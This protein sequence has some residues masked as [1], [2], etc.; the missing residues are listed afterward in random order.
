MNAQGTS[1]KVKM[2]LFLFSLQLLSFLSHAQDR[3]TASFIELTVSGTSTLHD[4]TMKSV[5]GDCTVQISVAPGGQITGLSALNFSTPVN[6]LKSDHSGMDNNAYK[7]LK[8]DKNPVISYNLSSV[9][10]APAAGGASTVTCKG[11]V[12][13][14]GATRDEEVVALCK[15]NPDNTITVKG[16]RKISM[17]DFKIDPPTFMLGTIKTGNDIVLNFTLVLKKS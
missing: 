8:S 7:A 5:K 4:W 11:T 3:Y 10:I 16:T 6:G 13:L 12:T 1:G 15:T 9:T 2:I 14:A 17:S